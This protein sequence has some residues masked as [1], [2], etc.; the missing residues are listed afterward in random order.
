MMRH[1]ISNLIYISLIVV[2][3]QHQQQEDFFF[4]FHTK[5]TASNQVLT[6]IIIYHNLLSFAFTQ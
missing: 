2:V 3:S 4:L 6:R 5:A 1:L